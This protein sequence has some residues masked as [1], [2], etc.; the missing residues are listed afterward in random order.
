MPPFAADMAVVIFD[1][2]APFQPRGA[3]AEARDHH[4]VLDRDGA[5]VIV[6]VERPGLHL[7]LVELA[8]VQQPMERMQVVIAR[9]ADVAQRRAPAP[10]PSSARRPCLIESA[11]IPSQ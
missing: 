5:L 3:V 4:R 6:A 9:R 11:V 1:P 2:V 7:P 10:R 8:A